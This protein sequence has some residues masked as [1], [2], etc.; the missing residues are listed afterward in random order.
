M[1]ARQCRRR[2]HH[3]DNKNEWLLVENDDES[4]EYRDSFYVERGPVSTSG[5][6]PDPGGAAIHDVHS[7]RC[8]REEGIGSHAVPGRREGQ[9]QPVLVREECSRPDPRCAAMLDVQSEQGRRE[10]GLLG[11]HAVQGRREGEP[12]LMLAPVWT[13]NTGTRWHTSTDVW[14]LRNARGVVRVAR[15]EAERFGLTR[16]RIC[17]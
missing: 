13:T 7:E 6:R 11:S 1:L 3:R 4:E 16:C 17:G 9:P 8:R 14:C 10:E 12:G 5:L 2:Q 15:C